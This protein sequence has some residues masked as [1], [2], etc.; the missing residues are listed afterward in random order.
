[1]ATRTSTAER[2][3]TPPILAER[4]GVGVHKILGWIQRGDL[5]AVNVATDPTGRP[6]WALEPD[7]VERFLAARASTPPAPATRTRRKAAAGVKE[8]F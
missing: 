7:E 2:M 4:L 5:R 3:I 6:R 1:M 8:Y